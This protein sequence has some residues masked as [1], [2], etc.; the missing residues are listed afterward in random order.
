M[1]PL[2]DGRATIESIMAAARAGAVPSILGVLKIFGAR[3]SGGLLS[4]PRP[5]ITLALDF[6]N[7]G[8]GLL[9]LLERFDAITRA[10]GGAVYPAKDARMSAESF[11]CFFPDWESL[12]PFVDPMF[13]SDFWRRV[14]GPL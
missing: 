11:R 4:F 3:H 13:S 9:E 5:G 6:P 8:S 2:D 10:A 1:V 14:E 7:H 12:T